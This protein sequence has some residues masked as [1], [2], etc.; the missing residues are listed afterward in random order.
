MSSSS[1]TDREQAVFLALIFLFLSSGLREKV[2]ATESTE[3]AREAREP[4]PEGGDGERGDCERPASTSGSS[5]LD[6]DG[7][8]DGEDDGRVDP[9]FFLPLPRPLADF[10]VAVFLFDFFGDMLTTR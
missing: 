1:S 8:D 4:S 7:E 3:E 6:D 2:E 5:A 10:L 9:V